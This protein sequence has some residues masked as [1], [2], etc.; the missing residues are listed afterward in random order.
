[1]ETRTRQ[2]PRAS[3]LA[4][5]AALS[6]FAVAG[7][8]AGCALALHGETGYVAP[9]GGGE[10]GDGA[11]TNLYLGF[12]D[13]PI[14]PSLGFRTKLTPEVKQAAISADIVGGSRVSLLTPYLRAGIHVVQFEEAPGG[15]GGWALG[16]PFGEAGVIVMLD[17]EMA[18]SRDAPSAG[19]FLSAGGTIEY[20]LRFDERP[21]QPYWGAMLGL[22]FVFETPRH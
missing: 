1:M 7:G 4:V 6:V 2:A 5:F 18:S 9:F 12:G 19:L 13:E 15:K 8:G 14:S 3:R 11:A 16:T 22:G 21:H 20:A 10:T 17:T